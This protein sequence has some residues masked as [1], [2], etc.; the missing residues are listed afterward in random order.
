MIAF[1]RRLSRT[2]A[3]LPKRTQVENGVESISNGL[4]DAKEGGADREIQNPYLR[5]ALE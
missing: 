3:T 1:V 2:P 4:N 5:L